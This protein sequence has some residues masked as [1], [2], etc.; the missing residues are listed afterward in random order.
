MFDRPV[1]RVPGAISTLLA[2]RPVSF[3]WFLSRFGCE[4]IERRDEVFSGM[5]SPVR[6]AFHG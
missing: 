6:L 4:S 5:T 3:A 1:G 2:G